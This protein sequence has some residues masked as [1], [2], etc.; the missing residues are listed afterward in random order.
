MLCTTSPI[1]A[2]NKLEHWISYIDSYEK[3][4]YGPV[5]ANSNHVMPTFVN[6]NRQKLQKFLEA[7]KQLFHGHCIILQ[8]V[9]I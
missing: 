5:H 4:D 9:K 6:K 8:H 7:I 2:D 1:Q 3:F